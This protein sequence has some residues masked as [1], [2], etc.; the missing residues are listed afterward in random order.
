MPD[1]TPETIA[2]LRRRHAAM[3][4][5][6]L[7]FL[8]GGPG[9]DPFIALAAEDGTPLPEPAFDAVLLFAELAAAELPALLDAICE[10]SH[11]KDRP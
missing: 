5:F 11:R 10:C 2:E 4:P 8:T 7:S 6:A 3:T 1:L 9:G